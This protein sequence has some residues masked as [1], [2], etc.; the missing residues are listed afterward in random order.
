LSNLEEVEE[1]CGVDG[2]GSWQ[3]IIVV[4]E[5]LKHLW[6]QLKPWPMER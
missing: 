2:S 5:A 6:G 3:I 1:D 4:G